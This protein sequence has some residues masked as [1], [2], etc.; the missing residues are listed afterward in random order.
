M[1]LT[2]KD[3]RSTTANKRGSQGIAQESSVSPGY[4]GA[5]PSA[6]GATARP[7]SASEKKRHKNESE[8]AKRTK[9]P[10]LAKAFFPEKQNCECCKGYIYGCDETVC[11]ELGKCICSLEEGEGT[12][13][14]KEKKGKYEFLKIHNV[15]SEIK[16]DQRISSLKM[17]IEGNTE[18]RVN[19]I[20]DFFSL[21]K[22]P[23]TTKQVF[24]L[25]FKWPYIWYLHF[26]RFANGSFQDPKLASSR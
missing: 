1:G 21:P 25:F 6:H 9:G 15:A 20:L 11:H 19:Q 26:V 3:G 10:T 2:I 18:S 12:G 16:E 13:E 17:K 14:V 8:L 22:K 4:R 5:T 24:R 7:R 23:P